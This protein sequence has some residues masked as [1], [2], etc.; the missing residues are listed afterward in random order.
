MIVETS[1]KPAFV[2]LG[3]LCLVIFLSIASPALAGAPAQAPTP[4]PVPAS[5]PTPMPGAP[6][7]LDG[8]ILF[9]IYNQFGPLSAADNAALITQKIEAL[10]S[11]PLAPPLKITLSI[12]EQGIDLNAGKLVLMTITNADAAAAGMSRQEAAEAA[13]GVIIQKVNEYRAQNTPIERA[14]RILIALLVLA[15]IFTALYLLDRFF[16]RKLDRLSTPPLAEPGKPASAVQAFLHS[17][18]FIGILRLLFNIVRVFIFLLVLFILAPHVLRLFPFTREMADSLIAYLND[19]FSSVWAWF[20]TYRSDFATILIIIIIAFSL[21]RL[22][23]AFFAEIEQQTIR[24]RH[25][26]PEWAPFTRRIINFLLMVGAVVVAFPYIPGSD[27]KAFQG[28]AIFLGALFTLASTAAVSNIVAG[29]IQTYTGAF[30]VD[31]VVRIGETTGVVLEKNLLTTRVRTFKREEVSIPNSIVMSSSVMNYS[32]MARQSGVILYTTVT[33]GYNAPWRQVHSLLLNAA[34]NTTYLLKDP[35]PYVRQTSLNDHHIS[36]QI[37][38]YT[39]H[40]EDMGR[41]YSELHANIQD[42]FNQAGVEIMSPLYTS[43]RDGNTVTIPPDW[44]QADYI[45]PGFRIEPPQ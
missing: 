43:L 30:R 1:T 13:A 6:V 17:R 42:S 38:C 32:I 18:L 28:I 8:E 45:A 21:S 37:N 44:R 2:L 29:V 26:E 10:A 9:Y 40:P 31:D 4:T 7:T 12:S 11:D 39:D 25:F 20:S 16:S 33:I 14:E 27:T 3:V 24:I 35:P 19:I 15:V 34:D 36:Y 22:V 23:T 5:A 41:I